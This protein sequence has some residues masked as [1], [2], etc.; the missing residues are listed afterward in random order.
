MSSDKKSNIVLDTVK[1]EI[2]IM[3][4]IKCNFQI[5]LRL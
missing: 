4:L 1:S 5:C 3:V 2:M